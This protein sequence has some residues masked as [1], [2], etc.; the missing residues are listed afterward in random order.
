MQIPY[1]QEP[2]LLPPLLCPVAPNLINALSSEHG[3]SKWY[4]WVK[5][6][7]LVS[8]YFGI[9]NLPETPRTALSQ[10]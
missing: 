1:R 9:L 3:L 7:Y 8:V 2:C 6:P 4:C 5:K 10:S